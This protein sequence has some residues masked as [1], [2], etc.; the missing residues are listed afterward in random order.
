M[1]TLKITEENV[2]VLSEKYLSKPSV[3]VIKGI[4]DDTAVL[5]PEGNY[6]LFT[7]D[8]LVE[9]THFIFDKISP[10]NLGWKSLA[11]NISDI[12]SMGGVPTHGVISLGLND[13][14]DYI[15]LEEFLKGVSDCSEL[16]SMQIVG[17]DTVSSHYSNIINV[18]LLGKAEKPVYRSTAKEG[19]ILA[20]TGELGAS[21]AG[22]WA[23]QNSG[24]ILCEEEKY[25]VEK[26]QKPYPRVDEALFI[27]SRISDLAM[28]DSSDGLYVSCKTL[29]E[30]SG[31]G[32]ELY[33][34]KFD[35]SENVSFVSEKSNIL[36][37]DFILYGGE[38]YELVI[39]IPEK[40]YEKIK[41]EY[42]QLFGEKLTS[43]GKFTSERNII[44]MIYGNSEIILEDKSFKHF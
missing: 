16:Y 5:K 31:T 6:Q 13:K 20:I 35:V 43:I 33:G 22:L 36:L 44:K 37:M 39:A 26:H 27:T 8:M 41:D 15:W 10:Y 28:L 25:C 24:D 17:G 3:T 19:Y 23:I 29:C 1:K 32:L 11:V 38:D 21:G 12:A 4:G 18:A 30:Q 14:V 40:E 9:G 7:T 34:E 42:Y 2:I